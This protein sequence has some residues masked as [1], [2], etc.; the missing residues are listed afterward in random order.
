M[1]RE[2]VLIVE[3]EFST[4]QV[5]QGLKFLIPR[6]LLIKDSKIITPC[7]LLHS[8]ETA[9]D[10]QSRNEILI[11]LVSASYTVSLYLQ[12]YGHQFQHGLW[13]DSHQ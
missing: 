3:R 6:A 1:K 4:L 13:Y 2:F 5:I 7:S 8:M 10:R 12:R 11:V 9:F